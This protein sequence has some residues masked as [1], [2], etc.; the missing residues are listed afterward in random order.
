MHNYPGLPVGAV[1]DP[2]GP[3]DGGGR[4]HHHRDRRPRRPRRAAAYLRRYGA[5][6][7]ADHQPDP[8]D[9]VAQR[10]SAACGG[11]LDLHVPGRQRRQRHSADRA[12][13]RHRPQPDARGPRPAGTAAARGRRG[14]RA[15]AR[16]Q[17]EAHL[18]ARLSGH[19]AITSGR[20]AFAAS[21]AAEVVG[22]ERGRR[23][24]SRR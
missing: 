8:V 3:A 10:R 5:G 15:A 14:H 13:A 11:G 7:R 18:Q 1:R 6:R 17:G 23:P 20:P 12:A 4:S 9:R 22:R 24:M 2:A 21:V 16:R 19:C